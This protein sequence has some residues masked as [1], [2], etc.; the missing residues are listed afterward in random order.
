MYSLIE[1]GVGTRIES[2]ELCRLSSLINVA[3]AETATERAN[4][5]AS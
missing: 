3:E 1:S 4:I 5:Y 2:F